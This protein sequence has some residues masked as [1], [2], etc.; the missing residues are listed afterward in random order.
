[1]FNNSCFA[2]FNLIIEHRILSTTSSKNGICTIFNWVTLVVVKKYQ[3]EPFSFF[4]SN[5]YLIDFKLM[6]LTLW[7][8]CTAYFIEIYLNGLSLNRSSSG[9]RCY[10]WTRF[11]HHD[12]VVGLFINVLVVCC[13]IT[14]RFLLKI[15]SKAIVNGLETC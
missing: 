5:P 7:I 6:H 8:L 4:L 13:K 3:F 9:A 14:F 1:M 11:E 12:F 10:S 2:I 15:I